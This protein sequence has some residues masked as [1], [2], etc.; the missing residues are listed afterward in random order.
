MEALV[1]HCVTASHTEYYCRLMDPVRAIP[2]PLI[3]PPTVLLFLLRFPTALAIH[4][5]CI[6][7][8]L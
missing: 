1:S 6:A 7:I 4:S 8:I 2:E 3:V 5:R